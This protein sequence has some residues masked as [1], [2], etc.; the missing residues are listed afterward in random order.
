MKTLI[1]KCER[2]GRCYGAAV[3][4]RPPRVD[5]EERPDIVIAT[6]ARTIARTERI[7]FMRDDAAVGPAPRTAAGPSWGDV[8]S[9]GRA[10]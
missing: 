7:A 10:L 3:D 5:E 6:A 8:R 4:L 2:R 1:S 9:L